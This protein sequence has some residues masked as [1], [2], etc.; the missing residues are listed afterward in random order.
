M[1]FW[2]TLFGSKDQPSSYTAPGHA[3]THGPSWQRHAAPAT[4]DQI[5]LQRYR[6]MLQTAPPE[7]IEQAHAEAFATLTPQQRAQALRELSQALPPHERSAA[8]L[9]GDDPQSLARLATRAEI[10]QPG[11]LEWAFGRSGGVGGIGLGGTILASLAVGFVGSMVAQQFMDG[12]GD[13]LAEMGMEDG[14]LAEEMP[15]SEDAFGGFD[16]GFDAQF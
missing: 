13:P 7:T 6:Y 10:R 9:S 16:D 14:M 1:G 12:F 8:D 2:K 11:T 4:E 5:A 3:A 15:I